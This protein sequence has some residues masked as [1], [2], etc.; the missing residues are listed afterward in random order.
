LVH[1]YALTV[2]N[3]IMSDTI[4]PDDN[5]IN[6]TGSIE[7]YTV[8]QAGTCVNTADGAEGGEGYE[9]VGG[10]GAEV[11]GTFALS[12]G[13]LS[14]GEA[15]EIVVGGE[16]AISGGGPPYTGGGGGTFAFSDVS[17]TLTPL[18]VAGGAGLGSGGG[19]GGRLG[20]GGHVGPRHG[21]RIVSAIFVARHGE[22]C[23]LGRSD[24]M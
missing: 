11:V 9:S 6:Y 19:A 12:A 8:E 14:A 10:D 5:A 15:I 7:T 18:V 13:A 24:I 23:R 3:R 16:G 22:S 20:G 17:G 4:T 2:G 1:H 21:E